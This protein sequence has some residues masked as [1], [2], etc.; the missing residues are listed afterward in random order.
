M[1]AKLR[2]PLGPGAGNTCN[3]QEGRNRHTVRSQGKTAI[4]NRHGTTKAGLFAH[5]TIRAA[6]YWGKEALHAAGVSTV[7]LM[8]TWGT[9]ASRG[10]PTPAG[11]AMARIRGFA[12]FPSGWSSQQSTRYIGGGRGRGMSQ[13][14]QMQHGTVFAEENTAHRLLVYLVV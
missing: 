10:N 8:G 7:Q 2:G 11:N 12:K 4:C 13:G 1:F 6:D 14:E 3:N 9:A 5:A